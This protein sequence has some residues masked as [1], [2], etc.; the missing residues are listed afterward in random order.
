MPEMI[1]PRRGDIDTVT[2]SG[3]AIQGCCGSKGNEDGH[4]KWMAGY[5]Q[6][7]TMQRV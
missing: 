7:A 3:S 2:T 1:W 4:L 6:K 5:C